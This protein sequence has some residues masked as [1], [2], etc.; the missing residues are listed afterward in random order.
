MNFSL[1]TRAL[2]SRNYKLFFTGQGISLIGTWMT[3]I[4]TSWLV[5]RLTGSAALLGLVG[6]AGQIPAFVLGPVAG[7]WVDRRNRHRTIVVTQILSML[8]SFALAVLALAHIITVWEIVVLALAQGI[9]NAFDMPA[10]Q[11]FVIQM[12]DQREDLP[13][14]IALNSSIV[15][16]SRLI[17]PAIA[18]IVVAAVGEGYCF[19]LDGASY[20]AVIVSLLMMRVASNAAPK[21]QRHIVHE[22]IDGWRYVTDSVPIR[23]ILLNLSIVSLFGMPYSVLMPIFAARVLGGGAHTLGFL[24]GAVGVGALGGALGL[25]AR[26]SVIG[27]GSRIF[28]TTGVFGLALVGFALSHWLWLS[29]LLLPVVGFG[30]MQQMAASNTV[31]QTIVDDERRGRVMAFYSM[32]IQGM[33]PFGSLIAGSTAGRVGAPVTV[34]GSGIACVLGAIWFRSRLPRIREVVRPVYV[35]MGILPEIATGVQQASALTEPPET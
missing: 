28:A 9:I 35:R 30:M 22:L 10:R 32:A 20:I 34:L 12:V 31:L 24:M 23:S 17:G 5:Y 15:N 14:A 16:A 13:N 25:A 4:A 29:M 7:V 33:A 2:R 18:G 6:F 19:L 21:P 3:R 27:L 8:Q 26:K 11:S 1:A